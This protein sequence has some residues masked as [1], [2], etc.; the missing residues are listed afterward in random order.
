MHTV[1]TKSQ[2]DLALKNRE[3][4]ITIT[5]K[6]IIKGLK[7][8]DNVNIKDSD[9]NRCKYSLRNKSA[10]SAFMGSIGFAPM[11]AGMANIS[12]LQGMGVISSVGLH[13]TLVIF[14][15]YNI[16]FKNDTIVLNKI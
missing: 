5:D 2:L 16:K 15:D 1:D 6:R 11:I 3:N 10:D 8:L 7:V 4:K 12:F 14:A 13:E 9:R